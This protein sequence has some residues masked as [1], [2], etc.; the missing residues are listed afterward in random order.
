MSNPHIVVSELRPRCL[1]YC[2]QRW[3]SLLCCPSPGAGRPGAGPAVGESRQV[4]PTTAR[5]T[6]PRSA[7]HGR[8]A[9][10][11]DGALFFRGWGRW[12]GFCNMQY[13]HS[14]KKNVKHIHL[15][16]P[17]YTGH[18]WWNYRLYSLRKLTVM[19]LCDCYCAYLDV[20]VL[21]KCLWTLMCQP[22]QQS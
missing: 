2:S 6:T 7:G 15:Y 12:G 16:T 22:A 9:A 19:T 10:G 8:G 13:L 18:L 5:P 1:L 3:S 4:Q 11:G 17:L 21:G 14:I 20:T